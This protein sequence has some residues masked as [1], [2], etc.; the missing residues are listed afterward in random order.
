MVAQNIIYL[1]Y[2]RSLYKFIPTLLVSILQKK[3]MKRRLI[4]LNRKKT[5]HVV[6]LVLSHV[7]YFVVVYCSLQ[8]LRKQRWY[9][10]PWRIVRLYGPF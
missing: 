4:R 6:A 5:P 2:I 9:Q 7:P 8:F 3:K 10:F 1:A